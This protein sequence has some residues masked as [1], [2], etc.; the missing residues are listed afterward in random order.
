MLLDDFHHIGEKLYAVRKKYGFTQ[1]EVASH[2]ELSERTYA[3]LER[4][5]LNVRL[6]TLLRICKVLHI[7]PDEILT[8]DAPV[9]DAQEQEIFHRLQ[10]CNPHD[11][12]TALRLLE[13]Y[14][15]SVHT[16]D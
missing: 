11:K 15:R 13:V 12:E 7:T 6:D 14:L 16:N 3:A 8:D 10:C 2:A 1:L 4:G 5:Q 9:S